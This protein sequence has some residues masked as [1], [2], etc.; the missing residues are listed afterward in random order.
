MESISDLIGRTGFEGLKGAPL[1]EKV[2]FIQELAFACQRFDERNC[3]TLYDLVVKP[4]MDEFTDE[5]ILR[6]ESIMYHGRGDDELFEVYKHLDS[7]KQPKDRRIDDMLSK[8][9]FPQYLENGIAE[10]HRKVIN[11]TEWG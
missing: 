1:S 10:I 9:P 3:S 4:A 11:S 8:V 5:E 7:M 6:I 2:R